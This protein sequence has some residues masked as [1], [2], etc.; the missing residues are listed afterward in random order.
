MNFDKAFKHS[1]LIAVTALTG[2]GINSVTKEEI[3]N[4]K[5]G[6][7]LFYRYERKVNGTRS[8]MFAER[9][10]R[11]SGDSVY[12]NPGTVEATSV[13]EPEL[14]TFSE[15]EKATTFTDLQRFSEE[16]GDEKVVIIRIGKQD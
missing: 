1:I 16:Q 10:T 5:P 8:W 4:I 9:V 12:Y 2:C 15:E 3:K 7:I 14:K 6:D 13:R 11:I